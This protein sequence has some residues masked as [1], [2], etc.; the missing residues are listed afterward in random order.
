MKKF[1]L[2]E[3][4]SGCSGDDPFEAENFEDA[5]KQVLEGMGYKLKQLE[6]TECPNCG[7]EDINFPI[8]HQLG[9][10]NNCGEEWE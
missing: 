8:A 6:I 5:A 3:A 2:V 10:C 9:E 7:C 4:S 1:Q